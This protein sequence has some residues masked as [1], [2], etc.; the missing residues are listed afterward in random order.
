MLLLLVAVLLSY[1]TCWQ[2]SELYDIVRKWEPVSDSL[3][4]ITERLCALQ[5][6]HEQGTAKLS[7]FATQF[8][9]DR[10]NVSLLM[11]LIVQN[12]DD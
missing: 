5:Q 3:P 6:L 10:I 9:E 4:H 2:V 11:R 12:F 7:N 8:Y 1:Y